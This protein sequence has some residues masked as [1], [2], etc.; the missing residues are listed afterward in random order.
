M[1]QCPGTHRCHWD[2]VGRE[3]STDHSCVQHLPI[4]WGL[5][6]GQRPGLSYSL[7]C[8]QSL[9]NS[10]CSRNQCGANE[11]RSSMTQESNYNPQVPKASVHTLAHLAHPSHRAQRG[12]DNCLRPHRKQG[13][14]WAL[15]LQSVMKVGPVIPP[16]PKNLSFLCLVKRLSLTSCAH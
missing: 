6:V 12:Q 11:S 14:G 1:I 8:S 10:T 13:Q 9:V 7:L 2:P 4:D 15:K 3:P 5:P 16:Y